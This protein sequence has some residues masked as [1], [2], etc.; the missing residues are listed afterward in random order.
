MPPKV[1][2]LQ[3]APGDLTGGQPSAVVSIKGSIAPSVFTFLLLGSDYLGQGIVVG[4][5]SLI[6]AGQMAALPG[7]APD[8]IAGPKGLRHRWHLP[9]GSLSCSARADLYLS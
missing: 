2:T 8:M 7:S 5:L 1:L 3:F 9:R 4:M 6:V